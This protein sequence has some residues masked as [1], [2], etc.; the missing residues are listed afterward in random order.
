M[1]K[2]FKEALI[3]LLLPILLAGCAK[4]GGKS[5]SLSAVYAIC[6]II[7]LVIVAGYCIFAKKK[8][9]WFI[10]LFTSVLVVNAGYLALSVS[11]T[12]EEALLA[13]RIAYL[14]SVF[15]PLFMLKIIMNVSRI[16]HKKWITAL[17]VVLGAVVL[18]IAGSPGYSDIYYKEVTLEVVNG[19]TVLNKVY[20]PWHGIYLLYLLGYF[21][22][23]IAMTIRAAL[24]NKLYSTEQTIILIVAVFVNIG[25]WLIEQFVKIDFE[26]LSISYIISELFLLGFNIIATE[27]ERLK[28]A[29]AD[30]K[31]QITKENVDAQQIDIT[32]FEGY[33]QGLS[34]LTATENTIFE[35]YTNGK[36]TSE[37]LTALNIKENTLK[38]HNKNIYSKLGVS[39]RKELIETYKQLKKA[40]AI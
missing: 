2:F 5:A 25:V 19:M 35:L 14:G 22:A 33:I 4:V 20:G 6:A 29:V 8:D 12:V 39:S 34:E 26:V 27:N 30:A 38:F 3:F 36:N 24:K 7:S 11:Q 16:E 9:L 23:I 1:K 32:V 13:N 21:G 31:S 10:L 28:E 37:V 15:L 17:L 40:D 18:V